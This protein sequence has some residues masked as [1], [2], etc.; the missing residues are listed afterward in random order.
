MSAAEHHFAHKAAEAVFHTQPG[1]AILA[2]SAGLLAAV[3]LAPAVAVG[4]VTIAA[5]W[6]LAWGICEVVKRLK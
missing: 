3:G 1:Q 4:A 6:G 2:S 5:T